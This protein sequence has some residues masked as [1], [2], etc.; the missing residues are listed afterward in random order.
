MNENKPNIESHNDTTNAKKS[1]LSFPLNPSTNKN[2]S[3]QLNRRHT[4]VPNRSILKPNIDGNHTIN[5]VSDTNLRENRRVS[6]AP[7]VTLHKIDYSRSN[8][9]KKL[10]KRNSI[11]GN[12]P[13]Q[14]KLNTTQY[15]W[16]SNNNTI[17]NRNNFQENEQEPPKLDSPV[18]D[19]QHHFII[20]EDSTTQTMEMSV[21][22]TQEILKQQKEIKKQSEIEKNE[23]D[24]DSANSLKD[25]FDKVEEEINLDKN[26]IDNDEKEIDMELTETFN[27]P[28]L[29]P[30]N[31]T[32][33]SMDL[34]EPQFQ[35]RND[36]ND[37]VASHIQNEI[38]VSD[39]NETM[40]F[41]QPIPNASS[42]LVDTEK[43]EEG[44][45]R[46]DELNEQSPKQGNV[47]TNRPEH[48]LADQFETSQMELTQPI[49]SNIEKNSKVELVED[50][51]TMDLTQHRSIVEPE[52]GNNETGLASELQLSTVFE[53]SEP[54]T[55]D[56]DHNNNTLHESNRNTS[57]IPSQF[58]KD[59]KEIKPIDKSDPYIKGE[60]NEQPTDTSI[61]TTSDAET[62]LIGTEMIPLA[63]VTGEFT[64]TID[65]Y[66]SD[67]SLADDNHVNVSLD[68]FL[69]D[70]N[71]QFYDNI[72]PSEHEI[73]KTLLFTPDLKS[74]PLSINSPTS[75]SSTS[76]TST[77]FNSINKRE[78]VIEYIDACTNIPYYHYI[79]HLINQYQSSIQSISTMVNTFSNDVLESNPIAIREYYQQSDDVK[80]DL[81]T[82]YQAIA[83]FTRKQA[84]CQNMRFVSG[85][86]E[87]LILSYERANQ[88]LEEELS[89]ALD[90][91]RGVL[92]E[93]QKMIEKK[94]QLNECIKKLDELRDNWNSINIEQIKKVNTNLRKYKNNKD[95]IK[96]QILNASNEVNNKTEVLSS[97]KDKK[98][99]LIKEIQE[100]K[101][102]VS[103]RKIPS[104]QELSNLRIRLKELEEIKG[105]KFIPAP[106]MTLLISSR[107]KV[108][109]R[110][111]AENNY[112]IDLQVEDIEQFAPFV[113]L[114]NMFVEKN[115]KRETKTPPIMF[116]KDIIMQWK[117]LIIIWKD[118]SMIH[119]LYKSNVGN[120]CFK[121]NFNFIDKSQHSN[122]VSIEGKLDNILDL[123]AQ[124]FVQ[125]NTSPVF[126]N[127]IGN[128]EIIKELKKVF[129]EDNCI[130]NRF[131]IA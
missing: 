81:C 15:I 116:L 98:D 67:N 45:I 110:K 125:F 29:D 71:V 124:I 75:S 10:K 82:N 86:L 22:L 13:Q 65:E 121:F 127:N 7:E 16:K 59:D 74:S 33:V 2:D 85:L 119:Y 26:Y 105:V 114:I 106:D 88:L 47:I 5:L 128:T 24:T 78:N 42:S 48:M 120:N 111:V 62:S 50:E 3:N 68:H 93:R 90:W 80:V 12:I 1:R 89:K 91:R 108:V 113:G 84:K 115:Q 51:E 56:H 18:L 87:Q 72:G 130:I 58:V 103:E 27:G 32:D 40:E 11:G 39:D 55:S 6:F 44:Q 131:V 101:S 69:H 14:P 36:S 20:D 64:D 63:E 53:V 104:Q 94:V 109:F 8:E 60:K 99:K 30:N 66:D 83:T 46:K 35:E 28:K 19:S 92:I 38:N 73:N 21:E 122:T 43:N 107:L 79:I 123:D 102:K 97:K 31:T 41:T 112:K 9:Q 57:I 61:N 54:P 100:L 52:D 49:F 37:L 95:N 77:P 129:G 17:T 4:L 126:I 117:Q 76:S 23:K 118:L 70:V 96:L 34:T 25:V